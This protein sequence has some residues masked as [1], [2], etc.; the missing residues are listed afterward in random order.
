LPLAFTSNLVAGIYDKAGL[1]SASGTVHDKEELV[2]R[3]KGAKGGLFLRAP[4]EGPELIS[5]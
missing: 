4:T 1:A 2:G 3:E 5:A